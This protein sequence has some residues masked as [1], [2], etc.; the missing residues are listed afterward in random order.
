MPVSKKVGDEVT[1]STVN[2]D[3]T[4][5]VQVTRVGEETT[6]SQIVRLMEDAQSSKAPIQVRACVQALF[7]LVIRSLQF[8]RLFDISALVWEM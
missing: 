2:N 8:W 7:R 3:G 4:I 1:G 6:L 5:H